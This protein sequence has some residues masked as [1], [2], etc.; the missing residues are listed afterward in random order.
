[1]PYLV[2]DA[3]TDSLLTRAT[4]D[5]DHLREIIGKEVAQSYIESIFQESNAY[6]EVIPE[7][8]YYI[9]KNEIYSPDIMIRDHN[10][11][12]FIDTKL[13]TPKLEI[14]KFNQKEINA[15]IERYA[16]YVIQIYHRIKEFINGS[17]Y[18]FSEKNKVDVEN[19]FGIVAVLEEAYI[20]R[21]QIYD[22]VI[23]KLDIDYESEEAKFIRVHIKFTNFRDL[24]SFA[25]NSQ[26]I[27]V[28]L[29]EKAK[30]PKSWYDI[31]LYNYQYYNNKEA[32]RI[33]SLEKFIS[34][35][36]KMIKNNINENG[37]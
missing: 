22:E 34:S 6:E 2:I 29:K 8:K 11:F 19:T 20:S 16:K 27:F 3:V 12:C 37:F 36:Q 35:I 5:D 32:K 13:S 25:F 17:Y 24:E 33:N 1:L 9:G 18:P 15:T 23:K 26:N 28:S 4:N 10:N 30:N 21:K 31:G 7:T 14:R